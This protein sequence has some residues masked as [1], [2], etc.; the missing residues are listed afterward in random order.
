M[1]ETGKPKSSAKAPWLSLLAPS[2]L[3]PGVPL[4]Y[5]VFGKIICSN[6]DNLESSCTGITDLE[7]MERILIRSPVALESRGKVPKA[8]AFSW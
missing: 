7:R 4:P 5:F 8:D 1:K 6:S 3:E 2:L